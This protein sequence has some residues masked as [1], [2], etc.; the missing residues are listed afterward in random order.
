MPARSRRRTPRTLEELRYAAELTDLDVS[1]LEP[2]GDYDL[3]HLRGLSMNAPTASRARFLEAAMSSTRI[4]GG[5]FD[6]TR[7]NDVWVHGTQ[8]AGTDLTRTTWTD[9][10]FV[11]VSLAGI[12]L[13]DSGLTRVAFFGCRFDSVNLRGATLR[14]VLFEDCLLTGLDVAGA[15]LTNV[16]F[17][18]CR[19][20]DLRMNNARL[21]NVD[22]RGA[23]SFQVG[24]GHTALRGG[25]IS[26][27]QA[28][29]LAPE[30]A[31]AFGITVR[32]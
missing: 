31:A 28:V 23:A 30:L 12:E 10:E 32:D 18:G 19:I 14:D 20:A 15:T 22:F 2:D 6:N 9:A 27:T 7:F 5:R 21:A 1:D 25:T 8:F 17:P 3:V 16:T 13:Y 29:E 11:N 4:V 26:Y 24:D